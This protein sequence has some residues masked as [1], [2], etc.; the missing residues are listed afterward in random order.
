MWSAIWAWLATRAASFWIA[1]IMGTVIAV[2]VGWI[3]ELRVRAAIC[4]TTLTQQNRIDELTE[5]VIE[6]IEEKNDERMERL[7]EA[8]DECLDRVVPDGLR[9]DGG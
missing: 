8:A 6:T 2:S 7:D 1:A 9:D 5:R 4:G 3:Q